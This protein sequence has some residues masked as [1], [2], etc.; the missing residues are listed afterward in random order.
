VTLTLEPGRV[1]RYGP[2][3]VVGTQRVDPSFVRFMADL[4]EGRA[5]DPDDIEDAENRFTRLGIFRSLRFEEAEEIGPDGVLPITIV[6][7]DRRRRTIGAGATLSTIDGLGVTAYWLNRNLYGRAEQLRFDASIDGLGQTTKPDEYDYNLGVTYTQPGIWT[8]DT[9]FVTG[10]VARQLDLDT[11]RERSITARAGISQLFGERLTGEVFAEVSRARYEDV[12]GTR[13]F[14]T[15]ALVTSAAYDR[16][17]DPFDATRGYYL[18]AEVRPFYEAEFDNTAI[19][20]TLEGRAYL[21]FGPEDRVTLA[22][23]AR[24]GSFVGAPIEESPPNLLFFAGGGGSVRGYEYRSIGV[25]ALLNGETETVGGRGLFEASAE[26]RYR[27]TDRF[28]AVGFVDAG[29]VSEDATLTGE[30]DLRTGA[31]LGVRYYTGIGVLRAD[32]ATPINPRPDDS[33]VALYIGIGQ[34]F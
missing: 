24:V 29:F 30:N 7:E 14:T 6:V 4:P 26:L 18:A 1:A 25:E 16:R 2:T 27:I 32:V 11:Y 12:F 8:P 34:A 15:F 21:S 28:G 17:D 22:G 3:R 10:L 31:G 9:N 20:G 23:R 33:A 13:N 19:R 5:F